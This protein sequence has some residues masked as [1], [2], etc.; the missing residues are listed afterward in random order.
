[1]ETTLGFYIALEGSSTSCKTSSHRRSGSNS[2]SN[3]SSS[4]RRR[5]RGTVATTKGMMGRSAACTD[6]N[7]ANNPSVSA[8]PGKEHNRARWNSARSTCIWLGHSSNA[9]ETRQAHSLTKEIGVVVP[10]TSSSTTAGPVRRRLSGASKA[11]SFR[12]L[13]A[14]ERHMYISILRM[15]STCTARSPGLLENHAGQDYS[16]QAIFESWAGWRGR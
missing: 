11:R 15:Q 14:R 12:F 6:K 16:A 7:C 1:M 8:T 3:N 10:S 9:D 4:S 13:S 5:R 2:S